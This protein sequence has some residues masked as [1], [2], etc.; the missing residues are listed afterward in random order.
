MKKVVLVV[1]VILGYTLNAQKIDYNTNN[2]VAV[3]GY[4]VVS[5]FTM[6]L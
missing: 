2:G 3:D 5:Y 6:V 1:F 4:D